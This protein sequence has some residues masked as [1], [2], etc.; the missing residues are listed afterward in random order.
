MRSVFIGLAALAALTV[1]TDAA[2]AADG[3]GIDAYGRYYC[4]P[5]AQPGTPY[6]RGGGPRYR[7]WDGN[8][9]LGRE[10][11]RYYCS[12]GSQTPVSVRRDCV[13]YGYWR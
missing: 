2:S 5:G 3:C 7:Q 8:R 10:E 9:R 12:M 13:R 6:Y 11:L 4:L 1:N